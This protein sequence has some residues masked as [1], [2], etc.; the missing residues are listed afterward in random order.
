MVLPIISYTLSSTKLEVGAKQFLPGNEGLG[1][2]GGDGGKGEGGGKGGEMAQTLYAHM[3]KKLKK[4]KEQYKM[5]EKGTFQYGLLSSWEA[6]RLWG[7]TCRCGCCL[8]HGPG[9]ISRA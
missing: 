6:I 9:E 3:N 7:S 2:E 5:F 8:A 4:N 1:G